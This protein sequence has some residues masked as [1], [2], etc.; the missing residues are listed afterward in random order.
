MGRGRFI[1]TIERKAHRRTKGAKLYALR[2]S[3]GRFRESQTDRHAQAMERKRR[4]KTAAGA[5][6]KEAAKAK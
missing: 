2:D 1:M 5:K 6:L 4:G 3:K